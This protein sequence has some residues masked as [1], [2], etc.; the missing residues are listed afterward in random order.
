[1]ARNNVWKTLVPVALGGMGG[2]MR[3]RFLIAATTAAAMIAC[4]ALGQQPKRPID[5][6]D[7]L[8]V[9]SYAVD[10]AP[11]A[12]MRNEASLA[13][14]VESLRADLEADLAAYDIRDAAALRSYYRALSTIAMIHH[15]PDDALNYEL[16][17]AALEE[18]PAARILSGMTLRPLIAAEKAGS[19]ESEE[20][21]ATAFAAELARMPYD[22]VQAELKT[23][24]AR[25]ETLSPAILEGVVASEIDPAAQGSRLSK[26]LALQL[27]DRSFA[28]W[29]VLPYRDE[30]VRQLTALID[31]HRVEKPDIWASRDV[32]LEDRQGLTSVAIAI[33]D[34]GVAPTLFAGRLWTN[35]KEVPGN[36][37][38][39]D[40]NGYVDDVHGIAWSWNGEPQS[41][42]LRPL[43]LPP[44]ELAMAKQ[45]M[46]GFLDMQA[47]IDSPE[48]NELRQR[49]A[50]L[51]KDEVKPTIEGVSFYSSYAHGT[52]VAGIA[53]HGNP[54]ARVL[55]AR[56]ETPYRMVPPP[57]TAAWAEGFARSLERSIAYYRSAGVRVVNMSWGMS[58]STLERGLEMN[59][60]G[61]TSE[62]R[63][64]LAMQYFDTLRR[65]F[66]AAIAAAPE[67]LFVAAAG[68]SNENN[69]FNEF[70]P[71]AFDLPNTM[72]VGAVDRAG[73][74]AAFTS[75][76]KVDVYANGYEVESVVPGEDKQRWSGTSMASPQVVNLAAKLLAV[77]P[78][79]QAAQVKN[80]IIAGADHRELSGGRAIQLLNE[81]RSFELARESAP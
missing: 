73:D 9:H 22:S 24:R 11:S 20:A 53:A 36:D 26:Q 39:D 14:L 72:S 37:K 74:E 40:E 44:A 23:T 76:G 71:A 1:M 25:L 80:L 18:K 27:I 16:K 66:G 50:S 54:A 59:G 55:I 49:L 38:D 65:I 48:A 19:G 79:L 12:M 31:S 45:L 41:G 56:M 3:R 70:L 60:I 61:P 2:N 35:P 63:R 51:S 62:E 47:A 21:F 42:E 28:R 10:E 57:P 32:S 77:Y 43:E 81:A 34:V 64:R 6:A 5:R 68:N 69:Q 30:M 8:P 15:R 29:H 75:F 17:A 46:K 78:Q 33:S 52:H 4:S 67:I 13:A 58:A 7:Q